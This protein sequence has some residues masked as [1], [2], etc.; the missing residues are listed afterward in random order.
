MDFDIDRRELLKATGAG[1]ATVTVASG[2]ASA[3]LDGSGTESDPFRIRTFDDLLSIDDGSIESSLTKHYVLEEDIDA[4]GE[5]QIV[6]LAFAT[7]F[8]EDPKDF[9]GTFDGQG[10]SII[11]LTVD[12]MSNYDDAGLFG[13][14]G[15]GG[16]VKN[17]NLVDIEVTGDSAAGGIAGV[18]DGGT[19]G[20]IKNVSVTGT[21]Q[22]DSGVGGIIGEMSSGTLTDSSSSAE[23]TA[24]SDIGGAIGSLLGGDVTRTYAEGNVGPAVEAEP[25]NVGGFV[26]RMSAGSIT[27]S[28]ATGNVDGKSSVGGFVGIIEDDSITKAYARGDI[29]S[30]GGVEPGPFGGFAGRISNASVEEV[31]STGAVPEGFSGGLIGSFIQAMSVEEEPVSVLNSHANSSYWDEEASGLTNSDGGEGRAT[32]QM[33]G[34]DASAPGNMDGFDF[35][36]TWV[37]V[38]G[39]ENPIIGFSPAET[40]TTIQATQPTGPGYPVFGWQLEGEAGKTCIDRRNLSRGQEDEECPVDRD[41]GRG[42]SRR[43]L[44]RESG[45]GGDDTHRDSSTARRDRGRGDRRG[46]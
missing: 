25:N 18:F 6:P 30:T 33:T 45:R 13:S 29:T 43:E 26:G 37:T 39:D 5:G 40:Q 28:F 20:K 3:N 42:G 23:V 11:G 32:A 41:I 24:T 12:G 16:V 9:T 46:R 8:E 4:T 17:V 21:V 2:T 36:N 27:L 35:E 10:N 31:Y 34:D 19:D 44:D 15:N 7:T 1:M 38:T 22:G 14:I